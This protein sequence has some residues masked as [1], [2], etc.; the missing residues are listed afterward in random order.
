M[1]GGNFS[2]KQPCMIVLV[3][4]FIIGA[5]LFGVQA[6]FHSKEVHAL[7]A[8]CF[9]QGGGSQLWKRRFYILAAIRSHVNQ[10]LTIHKE[11]V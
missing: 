2:V 6:Y 3:L 7:R 9:N 1:A 10:K 4:F 11:A 5:I 8:G